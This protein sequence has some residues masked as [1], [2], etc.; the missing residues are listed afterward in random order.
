MELKNDFEIDIAT[1]HTRLSKQW[2]NRRWKWSELAERCS[3]TRRTPETAAEYARMAPEEQSR[4][5][6]VG[7]FV[8]GYLSGGVRK[9]GHV[10]YRTVATLDIDHGTPDVWSD[11][12]LRF[13]FAALLY[14]THKHSPEHPRYRLVFPLSRQAAADEYEPLCR[15]VAEKLGIDLFDDTTY[16]LL[17]LFYWPSTSK[18]AEFVF[19]VQDG[20]ACDVDALLA[21]Y[22][23]CRDASCWPL[24]SRERALPA[25]EMKKAGD[26]VE[27]PG[28]IGAFCRAHAIEDAIEQF[29]PGSYEPA[30]QGRY[31]YKLGT[32]AGG[33]V[34]YEHKYAYSHHE[35]DPASRQLCNA[36]DL[37]RIHLFGAK[38]EGSR[39][40]GDVTRLPSYAAMQE[41]A[42]ADPKTRALIG[43][44]RMEEARADFGGIA[45]PDAGTGEADDTGW[46]E[47]MEYDKR[48]N[49][50]RTP[51]T[52]RLIMLNDPQFRR[53][54]F[55]TF[56]Q[57]DRIEGGGSRF[58]GTHA[59]GEVD[60]NSLAAMCSY[61]YD[62]YGIELSVAAL[63]EKMLKATA[64]ERSY[65]AVE[66]YMRGTEWDG[67]PRVETVLSDY[68]GA[69][70]N[71]L[72]RAVARKWLAGAAG[73][74]ID[75]DPVS[76]EGIKFDY[77][78]VLLGKQ[79]TGKSTFIE[80][81]AGRWRDS[82]SLSE[83]K[84]EQS[85]AFQ[86]A[87]IVEL[88]ELK[89][90]GNS[91]VDAVKD[92]MTRRSDNFRPAYARA[93]AKH[94][95]HCVLIGSTNNRYYL[96]DDTGSRRF[97][98]VEVKK[99]GDIGKWAKKL[100]EEAGQIWAEALRIYKSGEPLMLSEEMEREMDERN[101]GHHQAID[102]PF[103]EYLAQWLETRIPSDWGT[104]DIRRKL[105]Y[106]RDRD[107][108][109]AK[110]TVERTRVAV[111]E[112]V[113]TCPYPGVEKMSPRR[114]S[115]ILKS[116]DWL[117]E[118]GR[119]REKFAGLEG[120]GY[121]QKRVQ[122][123]VKRQSDKLTDI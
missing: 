31:T 63:V 26:P 43:R 20:P 28:I 57:S 67:K 93:Y 112:I 87:W 88:P 65:N 21:E 52:L 32:V 42:A 89:G 76:G 116:L 120:T 6:D 37:C 25:H 7:G 107:F 38:D 85:E 64:A 15:K 108:L 86:Q 90:N 19:E 74:A 104:Y 54:R 103:R 114:I 123:Y 83:G 92:L 51:R 117:P 33:L 55:D 102:D 91:D 30:G 4:V 53:V 48:G 105:D 73:R 62:M 56:S 18:D 5:K 96:R 39:A 3:Q 80:S 113:M 79:G 36:F 111:S 23:D 121:V 59:A 29:L 12:T 58:E 9:K 69:E 77:C 97:W 75:R 34:C 110:G 49:A 115:S 95:R 119:A 46:M 10:L 71:P 60:D 109:S 16:E 14:S 40:E 78:L 35:T 44:E 41:F 118:E 8:G 100:K 99:K 22:P 122:M 47:Q 61:L 45:M 11:F 72:N 106:Y 13:D 98:T 17:R 24:S 70:D 66:E 82:I 81:L 1:A 84:K 27:K 68:L 101:R 94:P 2:R 50:K